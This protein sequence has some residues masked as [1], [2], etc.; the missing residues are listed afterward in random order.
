MGLQTD[1]AAWVRK[2]LMEPWSIRNG[3]VVPTADTV[4]LGNQAVRLEGCVLYAD[5]ADSTGLVDTQPPQFAAL[6]YK[7]YLHCAAKLIRESGGQ[8]TAYDGDRIMAVFIGANQCA[9]AVTAALRINHACVNTVNPLLKQVFPSVDYAVRHTIGIDKSILFVATEGVRGAK[10]LVWVGRAANYA[11][12]LSDRPA[13]AIWITSDVFAEL[14]R[15]LLVTTAGQS[16]WREEPWRG[17]RIYGS[18]AT[19]QIPD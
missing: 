10:D 2:T 19:M 4:A 12:K 13:E 16:C 3:T 7:T 1:L 15:N 14:P 17:M 11:A 9:S 18:G 6:V 8:I 5:L